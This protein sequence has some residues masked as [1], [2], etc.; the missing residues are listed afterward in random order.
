MAASS[1]RPCRFGSPRSITTLRASDKDSDPV[2]TLLA[3]DSAAASCSAAVLANGRLLAH[4]HVEMAHGQAEALVPMIQAVMAEAKTTFADLDLIAATRGPG[5]FTGLRVGLATARG[6]ALAADVPCL[7]L[8]TTEVLA[9]AARAEGARGRILAVLDTRRAD[10][11][12]QAFDGAEA[13]SEPAAVAYDDLPAF[14]GP[15]PVT[16][17]G[18][19]QAR[20]VDA[21]AD[22]APLPAVAQPDARHVATAAA[23]RFTPGERPPLPQPLYLKPP[24]ATL[25]KD[26]GRLRP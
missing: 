23:R 3:L 13:L 1:G 18:D 14:A 9:E 25:P 4:A 19:A 5:S 8:T 16:V 24:Q 12:A 26:G 21:L 2:T 11:Y 20:A 22:A 7:G 6:L 15:G 17:V 10:V